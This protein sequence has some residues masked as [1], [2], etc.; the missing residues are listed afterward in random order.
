MKPTRPIALL[1]LDLRGRK[2]IVDADLAEIYGV[3]TKALGARGSKITICD[4]EAPAAHQAQSTR[5]SGATLWRY[6]Y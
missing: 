5:S 2:V 3:A 4:L 1:I 6:D